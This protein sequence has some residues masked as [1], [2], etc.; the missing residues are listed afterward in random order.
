[1]KLISIF[2]LLVVI[3]YQPTVFSQTKLNIESVDS[4]I[5]E[6]YRHTSKEM[7]T[8]EEDAGWVLLS[9]K[10]VDPKR[11]SKIVKFLQDP[12]N[13]SEDRALLTHDNVQIYFY[14][15]GELILAFHLSTLTL[16]MFIEDGKVHNTWSITPK[17]AKKI[18]KI[19]KK[20][21]VLDFIEE[22]FQFPN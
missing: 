5:I 13:F 7:A 1:M 19:L 14:D 8:K 21:Q 22:D 9:K 4:T 11:S 17:A 3:L 12:S 18:K 10:L 2:S 20:I 16:N 6:V 15:Q